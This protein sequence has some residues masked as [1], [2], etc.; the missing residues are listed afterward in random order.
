MRFRGAGSTARNL[1]LV[2]AEIVED[3]EFASR[4]RLGLDVIEAETPAGSA[5]S[6]RTYL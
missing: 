4:V 6:N 3:N 1:A 2:T 5:E